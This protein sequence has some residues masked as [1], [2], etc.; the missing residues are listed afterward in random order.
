MNPTSDVSLNDV[1]EQGD[2][3]GLYTV[4]QENPSVLED[5][6]MIPF[7][8]IIRLKPSFAGKLN[9]RGF[10][11]I[12]VALQKGQNRMVIRFVQINKDL[13]RVKGR[14]GITPLH[15]AS[16]T[17]EI[18]LL[19]EFLSACPDSIED[20]TVRSETALH[21]AVKNRQY[22]ALQVLVGW[23]KKSVLRDA[24]KLERRILNWKD[25][26]GNTILHISALNKRLKDV[27]QRGDVHDLYTLIQENPR[28]LEDIDA[29]PFVETPLH[30]AASAGLLSFATEIMRLKPSFAWKLNEQGFSPI[31]LALQQ[32]QRRMVVRFVQI[33]KDLVRVKGRE[34]I[35]PLHFASQSGNVDHLVYFLGACPD[36]IEDVTVRSET[37]LHIAVTNGQYRAL[38]VL[39]GWLEKSILTDA[40][41]LE[42]RI[43]NWKDEEGNT[44]LHISAG[45]G[46]PQPLQLLVK[47]MRNY[48]NAKNLENSTALDIAA[49]NNA[50]MERILVSGGAR[51]GSSVANAPS[52]AD[53]IISKV[54]IID[55]IIIYVLRTMNITEDQRNALLVVAALV[56]TAT[57]QFALSPPGGVYQAN[58]GDNNVNTTSLNS[59]AT[60]TG[61][62]AGT[63]V[64]SNFDFL[65]IFILNT[66]SFSLA[67]VTIFLMIPSG[68]WAAIVSLPLAFLASAYLSNA[69][70]ISPT[71]ATSYAIYI[72]VILFVGLWTMLPLKFSR[73]YRRLRGIFQTGNSRGGNIW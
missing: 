49:A 17:G 62:N 19:A 22:R 56:A 16:Q 46:D 60:A 5:I 41:E 11:P 53:T 54:P 48:L 68:I 29:I 27:S 8:E 61:G 20:V 57:Y 28:V 42:I 12:H 55:K 45:L 58:A 70:V 24:M 26:E 37:A 66:L 43:L 25:E 65:Y 18:N 30:A 36:S 4:I 14:E 6:D 64:M 67:I 51:R 10:S 59:K 31:H 9:G 21:I 73:V 33:N 2:I 69:Q 72:T 47:T 3:E 71:S 34:G 23:L 52:L 7:V 39:V 32:G 13:D 44:I 35:T 40:M 38:Q 63:S 1:A 15:L 50:E